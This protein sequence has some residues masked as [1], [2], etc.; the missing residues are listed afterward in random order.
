[1]GLRTFVDWLKWNSQYRPKKGHDEYFSVPVLDRLVSISAGLVPEPE[2]CPGAGAADRLQETLYIKKRNLT[3]IQRI[4]RHE[5]GIKLFRNLKNTVF[6]IN[7]PN[8]HQK[9]LKKH[10]FLLSSTRSINWCVFDHFRKKKFFD[11][12][13][14]KGDPLPRKLTKFFIFKYGQI[15]HQSIAFVDCGF[16][17][18][19]DVF[20]LIYLKNSVCKVPEKSNPIFMPIFPWNWGHIQFLTHIYF[21][22]LMLN[23]ILPTKM[24]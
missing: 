24:N 3:S 16:W 18:T 12:F 23:S 14:P 1:M 9:C 13:W 4:N 20:W 22:N 11:L 8:I 10:I 5:N 7:H 21:L 15:M 6:D 19:F 2:L 17:G